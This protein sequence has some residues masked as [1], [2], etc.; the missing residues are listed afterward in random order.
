[1]EWGNLATACFS[2][3]LVGGLGVSATV[4]GILSAI[5]APV[6][7]RR[8]GLSKPHLFAADTACFYICKSTLARHACIDVGIRLQFGGD[9]GKRWFYAITC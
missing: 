3:Y 7:L 5:H 4:D 9:S 1:M 6:T 2:G 8:T